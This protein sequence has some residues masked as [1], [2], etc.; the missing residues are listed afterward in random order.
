MK[1]IL[2]AVVGTVGLLASPAVAGKSKSQTPSKPAAKAEAAKPVVVADASAEAGAASA[3]AA[4]VSSNAS[5][6]ALALPDLPADTAGVFGQ[7]SLP[8]PMAVGKPI[9]KPAPAKAPVMNF[10]KDYV[11]GGGA[12]R[13]SAKPTEEGQQFVP[14][15]LSRVQVSTFIDAHSDQ[16]QL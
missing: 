11:L 13:S 1:T 7:V 3:V 6:E 15:G 5:P 2:V 10:G 14:K 9:A 8:A 12:K 4:A 16:L